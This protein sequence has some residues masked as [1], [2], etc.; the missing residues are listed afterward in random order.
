MTAKTVTAICECVPVAEPT[1]SYLLLHV[2]LQNIVSYITTTTTTTSV[3]Q[4]NDYHHC[5]CEV[6][7]G[8]ELSFLRCSLFSVN[9][10]HWLNNIMISKVSIVSTNIY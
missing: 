9:A 10:K 7:N 4:I 5:S 8:P 2:S 3:Q 6:R 1:L